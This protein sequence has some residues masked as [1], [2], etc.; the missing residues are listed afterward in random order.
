MRC[1]EPGAARERAATSRRVVSR[2]A[3]G[4]WLCRGTNTCVPPMGHVGELLSGLTQVELRGELCSRDT[5]CP[6][7]LEPLLSLLW[8]FAAARAAERVLW[9]GLALPSSHLL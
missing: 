3:C 2:L 1:A 5:W 9:K 7:R 4:I 8:V 6:G